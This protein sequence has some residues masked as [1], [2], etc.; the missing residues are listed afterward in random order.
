MS[1]VQARAN[2]TAFA[3]ITALALL[4]GVVI[5]CPTPAFASA[6]GSD[7]G[8][9]T[10]TVGVSDGGA[11]P[12]APGTPISGS[13]GSGSGGSGSWTCQ[14][15]SLLLNDEGGF[16][17]GGPTPGGWYSVTCINSTTGAS[18]TQTEWITNQAPTITPAIDPRSVA[19]QAERSLRLPAPTPHFNPSAS[20]VVNLP[21]WLWIDPSVWHPYAVTASVGA[22]SA[23]A[24]ATPVAVRWQMGDGGVVTCAGPGR[25]FDLAQPARMQQTACEYAY[26]TSSLGQ[27]YAR[28]N[29]D[30]AAYLVGAT[31]SW[32]VSWSVVGGVGEG[33]LPPLVTSSLTHVRVVEVESVDTGTAGSAGLSPPNNGSGGRSS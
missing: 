20:S 5:M 22:V 2:A 13:L 19:L 14:S 31:V 21:T 28:G 27:P 33:P 25:A 18:T 26:H 9:G 15:T 29:P 16:A 4:V 12:G 7:N 3:P 11:L 10:V 32:S 1:A 8:N 17:P 24:V 30:T 23:T 6:T